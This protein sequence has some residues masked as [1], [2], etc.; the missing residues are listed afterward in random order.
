MTLTC[1]QIFE[2]CK[3]EQDVWKQVGIYSV[4]YGRLHLSASNSSTWICWVQSTKA[5]WCKG[6]R[7]FNLER[8]TYLGVCA[9]PKSLEGRNEICHS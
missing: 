6:E 9:V 4:S 8:T 3:A 2:I 5:S 7:Q 1:T